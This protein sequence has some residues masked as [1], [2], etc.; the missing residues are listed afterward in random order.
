MWARQDSPVTTAVSRIKFSLTLL[1]FDPKSASLS[2]LVLSVLLSHSHEHSTLLHLLVL[3][4]AQ[5][6]KMEGYLQ[7]NKQ[8]FFLFGAFFICLTVK[9]KVTEHL[10]SGRI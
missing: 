10:R 6:L 4:Q 3:T 5:P 8:H 9:L 2:L 1:L 7:Q